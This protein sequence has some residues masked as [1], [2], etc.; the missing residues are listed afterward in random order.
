MHTPIH[1][2]LAHLAGRPGPK[3][4]SLVTWTRPKLLKKR[5]GTREPCPYPFG[6]E[7]VAERFG[8]IGISYESCV[9]NQRG[10]EGRPTN[11]RGQVYYFRATSFWHGLGEHVA[12]SPFLVRHR[13]T[14]ALYLKFMPRNLG[15]QPAIGTERWRDVATGRDV[16]PATLTGYL[17]R[18]YLVSKRQQ[19][20]KQVFWVTIALANVLEIRCGQTYRIAPEFHSPPAAHAA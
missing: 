9:N 15:N 11:R 1:V 6:V 3:I 17:P 14:G 12:G 7:K 2:A 4:C 5:R 13:V 19:T 8:M 10:R 16:D 18:P 20:R